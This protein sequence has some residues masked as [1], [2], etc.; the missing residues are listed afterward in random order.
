MTPKARIEGGYD[1]KQF[2]ENDPLAGLS[3]HPRPA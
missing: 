1:G 2:Y 3:S